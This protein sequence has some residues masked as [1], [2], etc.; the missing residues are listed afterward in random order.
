MSNL[1]GQPGAAWLAFIEEN[2]ENE[3]IRKI[4]PGKPCDYPSRHERTGPE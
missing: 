3:F 1:T 4:Q 2:T